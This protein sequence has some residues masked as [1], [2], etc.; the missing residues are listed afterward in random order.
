MVS[1]KKEI[2]SIVDSAKP[3]YKNEYAS[4]RVN[5]YGYT[6][7]YHFTEDMRKELI[8]RAGRPTAK[9]RIRHCEIERQ[10]D[11]LFLKENREMIESLCRI[12]K[13]IKSHACTAQKASQI[14]FKNGPLPPGFC[15]I[16][17]GYYCIDRGPLGKC[18]IEHF[19]SLLPIL[20][21]AWLKEI[22][23]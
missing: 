23:V 18:N 22:E 20:P 12:A 6:C 17:R 19:I 9:S 16:G 5:E 3:V 1:L 15:R 13:T 10:K 11:L 7:E 21:K 8:K 14:L 2:E 4:K